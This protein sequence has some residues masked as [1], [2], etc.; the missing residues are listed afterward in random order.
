MVTDN[1]NDGFDILRAR[2]T[3]LG[4]GGK[5]AQIPQVN[6]SLSIRKKNELRGVPDHLDVEE[7]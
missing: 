5:K 6:I 3:N 1:L 4:S 7:T 2:K